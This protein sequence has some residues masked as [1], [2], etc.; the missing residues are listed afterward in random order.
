MLFDMLFG[1]SMAIYEE[2]WHLSHD[3]KGK[4]FDAITE[5]TQEIEATNIDVVEI[6]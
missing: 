2:Y 3:K 4:T 1:F 5:F 6:K